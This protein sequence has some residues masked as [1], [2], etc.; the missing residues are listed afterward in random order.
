MPDKKN[1][2]DKPVYKSPPS[3]LVAFFKESRDKWKKKFTDAKRNVKRL[4][5]QVRYWKRESES[6][7]RRVKELEKE[8][9]ESQKKNSEGF[10]SPAVKFGEVPEFHKYSY[11]HMHLFL[12]L[13]LEASASMRGASRSLD[14]V[15]SFLELGIDMP[16]WSA[17]RLWLLRIGLYKLERPKTIADDWIWI[18]DHTVQLGN[19][20]CMVILGVRQSSLPDCELHLKHEDVE[21]LALFPVEKSNGE[22]VFQQLEATIEKTG[23]PKQIVMDHGTD[24]KGGAEKFCEKYRVIGTYDIKHKGANILKRELKDAPDWENFSTQAGRTSKKVQQ[25]KFADMA[26]P[27]QRSKARY[28]NL[29]KLVNWGA[30]TL[31]RLDIEKRKLGKQFESCEMKEKFGWACEYRDQLRDWKSLVDTVDTAASFVNFTGLYKG[32]DADLRAQL[33]ELPHN[34]RFAGIK[35]ELIEFAQS[36]QSSLAD[37][38]RLLG[39]SELIES[40][41][42]KYKRLQDDQVKGGFTGMLLGL[43]ASVSDLSMD[44]VKKAIDSTPTKKVWNWIQEKVGKS[45]HARRKEFNKIVEEEEQ[46]LAENSCAIYG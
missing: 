24:V 14:I 34:P 32:L 8:L 15:G 25:T 9:G 4:T 7:R 45:V 19:E 27:N 42:G 6:L 5:E 46:K 22:V 31:V 38:D 21:P 12:R 44:T 16:S 26:P 1:D 17:G 23:I 41:I 13:V 20:K 29:D 37:G 10:E 2:C 39:S 11:G 40:V 28:M 33:D 30:K 35:D 18:I 3:K 36:Q 43:A